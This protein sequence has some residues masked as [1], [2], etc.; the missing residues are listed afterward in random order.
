MKNNLLEFRFK[1]NHENVFSHMSNYLYGLRSCQD[2]KPVRLFLH[3]S[4]K[5][6]DSCKYCKTNIN[7]KLEIDFFKNRSHLDKLAK[8]IEELGIRDIHML[9]GGEPFFYKDNMFYFLEKIINVD[10]FIRI[11]TNCNNLND[12]DIRNIVKDGLVSQ[13]NIT[14]STD[15]EKMS[16]RLYQN[17]E[18]HVR[19]ISVLDSIFKFKNFFNKQFPR[20]D[21]MFVLSNLSYNKIDGII[22]ILKKLNISYFFMQPLRINCDDYRELELSDEQKKEFLEKIPETE[23]LLKD[24]NIMSNINDFKISNDFIENSR[25]YKSVI[26]DTVFSNRHLKMGCYFPLTTI[27]I[28]HDGA[29]PKCY[30]ADPIF[31]KNYF[32]I[33]SL[34]EDV[35]NAEYLDY[36]KNFIGEN[37]QSNC[38]KCRIC[39][40]Y[41][42]EEIKK[43]FV[44]FN[45]DR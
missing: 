23:K 19:T 26:P 34:K 45:I 1:F 3:P 32:T 6:N 27:S 33:S 9:G 5:C 36:I 4:G 8:D 11:I 25:D 16:G 15:S 35:M 10:A 37:C 20:I 17:K 44:S 29:I 2:I 38:D 42:I 28:H 22:S 21:I 24:A 41:E 39:I 14:L 31:K 18:R 7:S 40:L 12:S 13:L 43:M 30:F